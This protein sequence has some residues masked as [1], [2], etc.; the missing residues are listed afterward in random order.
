MSGSG[1]LVEDWKRQGRI[2]GWRAVRLKGRE[3][4]EDVYWI[5]V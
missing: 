1:S 2:G 5:N 4:V 3:M